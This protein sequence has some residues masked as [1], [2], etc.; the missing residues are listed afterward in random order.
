MPILQCWDDLTEEVRGPTVTR[1][2]VPGT[3]A[4]LVRLAITAGT[5]ADR[6][7]HPYEQFVQV[8]SGAGVLETEEGSH[9]F[10]AGSIFH[11]PPET[12]HAAV[13]EADTVLV[14]TNLAT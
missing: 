1:R 2:V 7:S 5:R 9:R 11:F 12:W 8:I 6:H 10:S 14:E 13:F 3:G 4:S